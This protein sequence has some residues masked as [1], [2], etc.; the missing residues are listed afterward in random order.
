MENSLPQSSL[1]S[2]PSVFS[3]KSKTTVVSQEDQ[4][5]TVLFDELSDRC[6]SFAQS[7]VNYKSST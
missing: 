1:H 5:L 2:E 6:N 4:A 3:L 7:G